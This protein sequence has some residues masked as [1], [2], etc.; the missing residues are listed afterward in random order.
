MRKL[1]STVTKKVVIGYLVIVFF[2]LGAVGYALYQLHQQTRHT[3]HLVQI[4]FSTFEL[5]RDLQQNLLAL[6]N[7]EK[8]LLILR[9]VELID[10]RRNRNDE[11]VRHVLT[12]QG[13]PSNE[14]SQTLLQILDAYRQ[15]DKHLA[16]ALQHEDWVVATALSGSTMVPLRTQIVELL[17]AYRERQQQQI[18]TDL[19]RLSQKTSAAF[20]ATVLLTLFGICLSAPVTITVIISI[21]RSVKALKRATQSI[22]AGR[23]DHRLEL[24]GDDEFSELA[25]DFYQMGEKLRELEQLHLDA[26]PLTLLPGNRAIDRAI[27]TRINQKIDFCHLYID[28]DNFKSYG[29]RYGYKAGSDVISQVGNLIQAVVNECGHPDDLVGHIGGDDYV[30]VTSPDKGEVLAQTIISR[31]DEMVPTLYSPEDRQAQ[32]FV[33]KDR[34]GVE[35]TFPLLSISIAV[36]HSTRYK[37]PSRLAISQDCAR[38]KEYL[39]LQDGSTYM[40]EEHRE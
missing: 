24:P 26:N 28:L 10:L 16:A 39:K 31:F 38:L 25:H 17:V 11:L 12:L 7:I 2:T 34:Y 20:R 18:N 23:F 21:H 8:Q 6:E 29:D 14:Q 5:L 37:Y 32:S 19:T 35:R 9:D 1:F 3:E 4:E 22:S 15:A 40:V 36:I 27:D 13:L 33:G 30:V